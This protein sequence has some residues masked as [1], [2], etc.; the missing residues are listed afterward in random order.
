MTLIELVIAIVVLGI[1]VV[2][3]LSILSSVSI[4]SARAMTRTQATAVA[5]AY[6]EKILAQPYGNIVG[7][8]NL[9]HSG[10]RDAYGNLIPGLQA[11]NVN[12]AAYAVNLGTAP[13]AV[14]AM[15]VDVTVTEPNGAPTQV[16]GF[17][18]TYT[19]QVIY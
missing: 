3:A 7:Y 18:T 2:S 8:N 17:R 6:L 15:R 16:S 10:A 12:V 5:A 1:C 19:G 13:N 11:Y 4:N 9:N 14:P